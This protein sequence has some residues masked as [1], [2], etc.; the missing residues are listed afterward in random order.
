MMSMGRRLVLGVALLTVGWGLPALPQA[1]PSAKR[2]QPPVRK[3][4]PVPRSTPAENKEYSS[5]RETIIDL[6]PPGGD[7]GKSESAGDVTEFTPYDPHKA[8]KD[9]EVGDYY[10]K[11]KN[12]GAAIS[13]Y[14]SAL[15]YKPNDAGAT[16]RLAR[17]LEVIG[18]LEESRRLFEAYL[19]ILPE[20]EFAAAARSSLEKLKAQ[21]TSALDPRPA[22]SPPAETPPSK[23]SPQP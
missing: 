14:R 1:A 4:D 23:R 3:S 18:E 6:T 2:E 17:A 15:V 8:E 19:K 11:R 16:F 5:S 7:P 22:T 10:F 9:V 20:G 13:R 21:E 12:Y